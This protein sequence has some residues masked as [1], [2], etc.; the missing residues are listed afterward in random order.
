LNLLSNTFEL[1]IP[2]DQERFKLLLQ[3]FLYGFRSFENKWYMIPRPKIYNN[4][5]RFIV[6][7]LGFNINLKK[8][9]HW[10]IPEQIFNLFNLYF[11]LNYRLLLIFTSVTK[12]SIKKTDYLNYA[13]KSAILLEVENKKLVS[14]K[15]ISKNELILEDIINKLDTIHA[16]TSSKYGYISA[17]MNIDKSLLRR[18]IGSFGIKLSKYRPF[19]KSKA[20]KMLRKEQYFNIYPELPPYKLIKDKG[21]VSLLKIILPIII[22]KHEF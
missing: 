13:F 5:N 10:A 15:S 4:L 16:K 20:Y 17:V 2:I 1:D 22:D 3:K 18:I 11:G 19:S 12:T 8:L 9:S 21:M 7:L 6:R 14:I